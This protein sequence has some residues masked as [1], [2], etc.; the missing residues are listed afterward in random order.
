MKWSKL[1]RLIEDGFADSFG[2]RLSINSTAYGNCSCGH[3]W[4]TL[5]GEVIA[6]FCTRA[7]W[8]KEMAGAN[9]DVQ[10]PM[11]RHQYA[12]YGEMSRQDVYRACWEF[13]HRL[14]VEKAL[15]ESDPL[16]QS[17]AVVDRRVGKRRLIQIDASVLH[18]L[19]RK[20]FTERV[21]A[22]GIPPWKHRNVLRF[23]S[24]ATGNA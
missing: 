1:K 23:P 17:L 9:P 14:T 16:L 20:L 22:E 3:A 15:Q 8:T 2:K 12:E 11:Y 24:T 21:R 10:N 18:P 7:Y 5:D 13:V 4:L 19:A 6:N